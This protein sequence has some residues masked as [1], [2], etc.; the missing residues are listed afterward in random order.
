VKK[1]P[2]TGPVSVSSSPAYATPARKT[3]PSVSPAARQ[4][5]PAKRQKMKAASKRVV[6]KLAGLDLSAF[7]VLQ[8]TKKPAP[9]KEQVVSSPD[10]EASKKARRFKRVPFRENVLI[11]KAI[12]VEGIDIS[13]GG[14]F[15][16]TGRS[17]VEGSTVEVAIPVQGGDFHV[18]AT[19]QHNQAGVGMG[20]RFIELSDAQ[21]GRLRL[22]I[23]TIDARHSADTEER[24]TVLL[25][26]GNETARRISKSKLIHDGYAVV[27]ATS[28][29]EV[30]RICQEKLP[31]IIVL[32]WQDPETESRDVL[33]KIRKHPRWNKVI[34]I[35]LSGV[36]DKEVEQQA[37]AAGADAYLTKMDTTPVKLAAKLLEC[38]SKRKG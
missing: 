24:K 35:A 9:E 38:I 16:F 23:E 12:L 8:Q 34:M 15:V 30:F 1:V 22:M 19:V 33:T 28:R 36:S 32:D 6:S 26:G 25:A 29:D 13:E 4:A 37:F 27:E 11:D 2:A 14:L 5:V 31:D 7:E 10:H 17:F 3:V 21:L 18:K 20:L